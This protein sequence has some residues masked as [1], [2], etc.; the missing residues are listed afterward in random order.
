[1]IFNQNWL[2][3]R[4][5]DGVRSDAF[6]ASVPG[7]IQKDWAIAHDFGDVHYG[8]NCEKFRALEDDFWEYKTTLSY[9]ANEG[10]RVFFV[11]LG[12]D[13]IYD[14]FLNGECIHS[15]EGMFHKI[16]LDLTEKL[17][18]ADNEL[19]VRIHPHPKR[20]GSPIGTRDEADHSCKPPVCYGWDW[21]PRLL[22]SGLWQ[23]AYVE[24][25]TSAYI[26]NC[27]VF[28][29]LSDD[30]SKADVKVSIDC[31]VPCTFELFDAEGR[32]VYGGEELSFTVDSPKLWWC[33]G[34][35]EP[36]LYTYKVSNAE[37]SI[38]GT[39]G[40]RRVRMLR[41]IGSKD[42]KMFPKSRYDAPFSL[43]LNGR[44]VFMKGSNWVN[45]DIFWGDIT[46]ERYDDI[47]TLVRDANM[48]VLRMWGG[49]AVAKRD[50]YELCDKYGIMVWQ[51]FMLACNLYPNDDAYLSVL[52]REARAIIT[53]P[54]RYPSIILWC[55]GNE[56]FNSWSGMD[57]QSLP[58]RLLDKLCYEL[59]RER[60]YIKTSPLTGIGHG[61]YVFKD[62]KIMGGD[63][64]YSFQH[65]NC[66][67]YT[68]FGVPSISSVDVLRATIPEDELFP[69]TP[70][71]S[72][73]LHH[74]W[75]AWKTESHACIPITE[76]YFGPASSLE[77]LVEQ[78]NLLQ[79]E[80]YKACFEEMRKQAPHC[81]AA[82]NWCLNEP[83]KTAA[84]LSVIM[85]PATPKPAYYA[86]T[87]S[88]RPVL[89]SARIPKFDWKAGEV[90]KAE[91]WLLN[92][93]PEA[94]SGEV[95]VSLKV[96]DQ[97][98]QLLDWKN[99]S[100]PAGENLQGAQVCCVLPNAEGARIMT[101]KLTS[102]DGRG[103]EYRL[104]YNEKSNVVK[105]KVLN[106]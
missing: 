102:P 93:S 72:Y 75:K 31:A 101:L 49:A 10:E 55:G 63:V 73:L 70:T 37:Y 12:I 21:N 36:Y 45:P 1:M 54:R 34:Q 89:F 81:S 52:E 50:F 83:W 25:R 68:E 57:D 14:V 60:P 48:N 33:N 84:N 90:F 86:I 76:S 56:L 47:L 91:I 35:G 99:A 6:K 16:E 41:N 44:R 95:S 2:G 64:F 105:P 43:E 15:D 69:I 30:F 85:Y 19:T 9:T 100:A 94:V 71:K 40:F 17:S 7:N 62:D 77:E 11:S 28:Y 80:G 65:A 67:A 88:L 96:G 92:D 106:L 66:V 78:T 8:D 26:N 23:E 4:I 24:T 27:E 13:Y 58:L 46:R 98:L 22:I 87:E 38:F 59:D 32:L 51:E 61:C 20:K 53:D 97:E 5:H 29:N 104:V 74:A 39:V 18:S 42:P 82:L 3:Y 103:S 79:C